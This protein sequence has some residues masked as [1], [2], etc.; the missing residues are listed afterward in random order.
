MNTLDAIAVM[1]AATTRA[2][3]NELDDSTLKPTNAMSGLEMGLKGNKNAISPAN[4]TG[5]VAAAENKRQKEQAQ[6][7]PGSVG[8]SPN[9]K[10]QALHSLVG[11]GGL[12]RP[13]DAPAPDKLSEPLQSA[14]N[15]L[16]VPE[17]QQKPPENTFTTSPTSISS[18]AT[19]AS[20]SLSSAMPA[21]ADN[22]STT[23]ANFV[24]E[25]AQMGDGSIYHGGNGH[26]EADDE[27]P[28][29]FTYP[30]PPPQEQEQGDGPT[31]GMS[32]PGYGQSSPKSPASNKRHKCPYCPTDFTR[33]H[34]LKSHLLTHSQEKPFVCQ[35]CQAR[36]RRLHD[37]KRHSKLHTGERPHICEKC[38]RKFARGDALARHNKGPRR[39][40]GTSR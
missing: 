28:Q 2:P 25:P 17:S 29:A 30:G 27:R 33:H 38:G 6:A 16:H 15:R 10:V 12:S 9:L 26:P 7:D 13:S 39:L 22:T 23:G 5:A 32:L 19:L 24:A 1:A 8:T 21:T 4:L 34:N 37:L 40:C 36:F 20:A 11:S 14:A 35:T 18:Y 31:R 3:S